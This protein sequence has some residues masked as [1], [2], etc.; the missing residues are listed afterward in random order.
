MTTK[1]HEPYNQ[2][3]GHMDS[4]LIVESAPS[5]TPVFS[6][7]FFAV[8][9][10]QD[11]T[12]HRS[13]RLETSSSRPTTKA[14]Y[15]YPLCACVTEHRRSELSGASH[16]TLKAWRRPLGLT[17]SAGVISTTNR[18]IDTRQYE[19]ANAYITQ[20]LDRSGRR[21]A[22]K[23]NLRRLER[24]AEVERILDSTRNND[25][26][27]NTFEMLSSVI[28]A[29]SPEIRGGRKVRTTTEPIRFFSFPGLARTRE[30]KKYERLVR[31]RGEHTTCWMCHGRSRKLHRIESIQAS[32]LA[33]TPGVFHF[34]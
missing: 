13:T 25:A 31:R 3:E 20:T 16:T 27:S 18:R 5:T 30:S 15:G 29:S 10:T 23:C 22:S 2:S 21:R 14:H 32:Q 8:T 4:R 33:I 26:S 19:Y 11:C 24:I 1:T 6:S 28:V 9:E 12:R 17:R 7:N 34:L